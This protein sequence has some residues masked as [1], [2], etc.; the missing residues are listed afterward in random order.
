VGFS[1]A[2]IVLSRHPI[3]YHGVHVPDEF[4]ITSADGLKHSLGRI[5][6]MEGGTVW[7]DKSLELPETKSEV[8]VRDF[9]GH[10]GPRGAMLYALQTFVRET[11]VIPADVLA[12]ML[13]RGAIDARFPKEASEK[14]HS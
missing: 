14:T 12:E 7:L 13:Q 2:E 5:R 6:K 4:I 3:I 8:R 9:R 10:A 11:G 1:T